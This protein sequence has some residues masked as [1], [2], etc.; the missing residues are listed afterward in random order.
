MS[1]LD[2]RKVYLQVCVHKS[3]WAY[4]TVILEGKRYCLSRMGFGLNVAPSIMRAIVEVTLS[5]DDAVQQATSAYINNDFINEDIAFT[6]KVKQHLAN[7][8]LMSKEL[9]RLQNGAW[10]A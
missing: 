5:K 2:L 7:F 8:G 10:V 3:L 4:Q 6:T 1:V 9:E